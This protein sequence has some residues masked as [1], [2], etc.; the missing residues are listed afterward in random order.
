MEIESIVVSESPGGIGRRMAVSS[1]ETDNR[2]A[3]DEES[4]DCVRDK[5]AGEDEL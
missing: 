1:L 2:L 3:F 5:L 4:E